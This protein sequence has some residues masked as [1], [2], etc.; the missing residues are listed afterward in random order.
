LGSV[1]AKFGSGFDNI[2][3]LQG[4]NHSAEG[5]GQWMGLDYVQLNP[6]I[7]PATFPWSV[8]KDDDGWPAGDGGGPN[9]TFVQ[10]SFGPNALPGNPNSPEVNTQADDDYYFAGIY[11]TVIPS[12]GSYTPVGLV[13]ANEEAAERAFA[14]IDNDKRYHFN[15]PA[16][17]SPDA[18]LSISW[19]PLNLDD[20][21]SVNTDPRYG[22]EV[23]FNGVKVQSEI[24]VRAAQLNQRF[25][26]PL[27]TLSSVNAAMGPGYDNIVTL[28]GINH[29]AEG[30]GQ[31]MGIDYVQLNP[32]IPPPTFPWA[33]GKND[34]DWPVG[35]GGGPNATFVQE[36][37]VNPLP[38]NPHSPE[39]NQ[40]AD[41]DYY[42]AGNYTTVIA[43]N[44]SYTPVGIVAANEEA[45]ER[46]FAGDDNNKRYHFNLPASLSPTD[47][48]AVSF[49][50]LNLDDSAGGD[51]H[52]GVEVYFNGVKVQSEIVIHTPQIGQTYTTPAFTLASVNAGL[53]SGFDNIV[54]LKGINHSSE[55]GG[56][57]MGIDYIQLNTAS[58]DSTPPVMTCPNTVSVEC[59][60]TTTWQVSATDD[61]DGVVPV[62]CTP[63]SSA[64]LSL[65]AHNVVCTT[66]DAAGNPASCSFP[67]TVVDT[68]PPT[69]EAA[70]TSP[71]QVPHACG[72]TVTIQTDDP[73]GVVVSYTTAGAEACR[74][75]TVG[76]VPPS[77]TRFTQGTRTVTCTTVDGAGNSAACSFT[78]RVR[79]L[80]ECPTAQANVVPPFE[81]A[82]DGHYLVIAPNNTDAHVIFDGST[83]SDADGDTLS[84]AW[85]E[86][87]QTNHVPVPPDTGKKVSKKKSKKENSGDEDCA[88]GKVS[89][90][91][92]QYNGA[93]AGFVG[94]AQ[95]G[96]AVLFYEMVQ[97]GGTF[98]FQGY[99]KD[100]DMSPEIAVFLNNVVNAAFDTSGKTAIG[101][102]LWS[103]DFLV[104]SG[105]TVKDGQLCELAPPPLTERVQFGTGVVAERTLHLGVHNIE[106]EV[107]D[108]DCT[109]LAALVVEV[110]TPGQ[111]VESCIILVA[112][113]SL[114]AKD[115]R[116]LIDTL[117]KAM[118]EFDKGKFDQGVKKLEEFIKKVQKN[119]SLSQAEKDVLI[120]CAQ[121][122][123]DVMKP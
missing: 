18:Q 59:G 74:I 104:I 28:K 117:K 3:T 42:F 94:V 72:E 87:P 2:V 102:G 30:G 83:S 32:P 89:E 67:V 43:G 80:N 54:T 11:S 66:A 61:V 101:P 84:Y 77:G 14:G 4:I 73:T 6:P 121:H 111:A 34:N 25:T 29:S 118:S 116:P 24:I 76:C 79:P 106:L 69:I 122:T 17:L 36:A 13:P 38:G 12:N 26:T 63:P 96:K 51:P 49:D 119:K 8:G 88:F 90:L 98:T 10:E 112:H 71:V 103:G 95:K 110:I 27:F 115:Q 92:L 81:L 93:Q 123:I 60:V 5:G 107:S 70:V 47:K 109:D 57:W 58:Q 99:G 46:A 41:D 100:G 33:V 44:G 45:A 23:Y 35:D 22:V 105:K 97:P 113:S 52:Y 31:W 75:A 62:V 91:T 48:V 85:F 68:I 7:P 55:G 86:A 50:A 1:N 108:A 16:N 53:G 40:Q 20:P 37:G 82:D 64:G 114:D 78:V 21:S 39:V 15:L 19:D 65:G 9:A 120:E 56:Q